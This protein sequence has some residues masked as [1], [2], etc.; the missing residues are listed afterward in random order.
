MSLSMTAIAWWT[1]FSSHVMWSVRQ[2]KPRQC[3]CCC[4][5]AAAKPGLRDGSGTPDCSVRE[6]VLKERGATRAAAV[7][8]C[9]WVQMWGV[10]LVGVVALQRCATRRLQRC[11]RLDKLVDKLVGL[12]VGAQVGLL[13][14]S[15]VGLMGGALVDLLKGSLVGTPRTGVCGCIEHVILLLSSL[16]FVGMLSGACTLRTCCVLRVAAG[17]VVSS[18]LLGCASKWE[19]V[20]SSICCR[21]CAAR[22]ILAWPIIP[23]MALTQSANECITLLAWVMVG[24]VIPLCWNWTVSDSSS[25]IVCFIW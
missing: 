18:N 11:S 17:V 5:T 6:R 23:W 9:D 3:C 22:A 8:T 16:W 25:L 12:M 4:I 19:S 15:L 20:A 1:S 2:I 21:S 24:L 10:V 14:G 7:A 13:V